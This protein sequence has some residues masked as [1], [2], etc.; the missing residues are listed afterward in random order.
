[1]MRV[2]VMHA[3]LIGISTGCTPTPSGYPVVPVAMRPRAEPIPL[4]KAAVLAEVYG[5]LL[6]LL[7]PCPALRPVGQRFR[8]QV[9][10]NAGAGRTAE[11]ARRIIAAMDR[12][13]ARDAR[14]WNVRASPDACSKAGRLLAATQANENE[15]V[16]ALAGMW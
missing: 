13:V 8:Q 10:S 2:A 12:A 5:Q 1:M 14:R 7:R 16:S 3:L 4:A 6:A 11:D 9:V 15:T